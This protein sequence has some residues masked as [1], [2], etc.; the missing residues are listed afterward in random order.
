MADT[1]NVSG[2]WLG[3]NARSVTG[4]CFV[5]VSTLAEVDSESLWL[6]PTSDLH[7]S[8]QFHFLHSSHALFISFLCSA[9]LQHTIMMSWCF[10]M[11]KISSMTR[12][13][14]LKHALN[15]VKF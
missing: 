1:V 7:M 10:V 2:D 14:A 12:C 13:L 4:F 11:L 8:L 9:Q 6:L 15:L 5:C 3:N